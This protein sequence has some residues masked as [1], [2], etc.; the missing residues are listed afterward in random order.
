VLAAGL[1]LTYSTSGVFNLA[2]GTIAFATAYLFFQLHTGQG[3]P[4]WLAGV[5][6]ILVFAPLL[7]LGLDRLL[8]RRLARADVA[9]R[10]VGTIGL[11]VALPALAFWSIERLNAWLGWGL[12]TGEQVFGPPGLGPHPPEAWV[13]WRGVRLT[14]NQLA[15][16]VAALVVA[17]ALWLVVGHTRLGLSMRAAVDRRDLASLRGIDPGRTSATA[18]MLGC[19]LAGLA[20][21]LLAPLF[22]L[23]PNF[24]TLLLFLAATAAVLGGLRSIPL[25]FAGG[26]LLGVVQN[27]VAGYAPDVVS[28]ISG[29]RTAVPFVLLFVG[30]LV[31]GQDRAR[32][33]PT[34]GEG[35][36]VPLD[37]ADGAVADDG[38]GWRRLAPG[39]VAALL[40]AGYVL[41][42]A[43]DFWAGLVGRGL[44]LGLVFL[45]FVVVTGIGGLV[46]LAGATFVTAGAMAA[47]WLLDHDVPFLLAAVGAAAVA[48]AVGVLVALPALRLGGLSLALA[49]LA[50]A[51]MGQ[52]LVFQLDAVRHGSSGWSVPRPV[53][54]PVDF[55]DERAFTLLLLVL[56]LAGATVVRNLAHSPSGRA[57]V[58]VR[59]SEPAAATSGVAPVRAKLSVFAVSAAIAGL[60]GT[61]LA[62]GTLRV[63]NLDYPVVA[64]LV[65]L[66]VTVTFGVRRPAGAVVAGLVFATLPELA[67]RVT[68]STRIPAILF[69]LGAVGLARHPDGVLSMVRARRR[70]ERRRE[71]VPA[72]P[73][74]RPPVPGP[75]EPVGAD[76]PALVLEGVTGGYG[77]VEVLHGVD[78]VVPRGRVVALLGANGAGK[79]TIGAVAAGLLTPTGG[80]VH[81]D[82]YDV[83]ALP[84]HR[85]A[86]AG[87]LLVPETRGVF[88]GL[89]VEENLAV[90]LPDAAARDEARALFPFLARRRQTAGSLS[91][92]EQQLLALAPALVRPPT[93]L[94]ADEPS[95]GLAPRAVEQVMEALRA[96][97]ARGVAL[98]VVEEKT[99]EALDLAD[100][101]AV[102][103]R[104]RVTWQG[105]RADVDTDQL[106][107]AYLGGAS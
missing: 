52:E 23:D 78:L 51:F 35:A 57:L 74:R 1:V 71:R 27:L 66:A 11:L 94:I 24:F 2:H 87:L 100:E 62:A 105:R 56:V 9:A 32:A 50:L 102:V 15:V 95:L 88:P 53:L 63:S 91:G 81:L 16:F 55:G 19:G 68:D 41:F 22:N 12:P 77:A 47:G 61:M 49:T 82:G 73:R 58:A 28:R 17:V 96:L 43:D 4:V 103:E 39:A 75:G 34:L 67:G 21:V 26:L 44:A 70:H 86:A 20:G 104:G 90:H 36:P 5:V 72:L 83:T 31:L 30:L 92:G 65:W 33:A 107:A 42:V 6:S 59:S 79:S 45:S 64:G 89:T 38:G 80:R 37:A 8:F 54:G 84:A 106:A 101:V 48:T 93:V 14:S 7:G 29:F 98:L 3:W 97:A 13:L 46:N 85:R 18:W 76:T 10:L 99:R 40:L 69:G 25:A 60:G